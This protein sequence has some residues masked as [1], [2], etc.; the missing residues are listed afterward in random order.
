MNMNEVYPDILLVYRDKAI[1]EDTRSSEQLPLK[2]V[3]KALRS[4]TR[5]HTNETRAKEDKENVP[6]SAGE[7]KDKP[8]PKKGVLGIHKLNEIKTVQEEEQEQTANIKQS[9]TLQ[10][11][12]PR[13]KISNLF[14]K[15]SNERKKS[16]PQ[17]SQS[18]TESAESTV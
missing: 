5:F 16:R 4:G 3:K 9:N 15:S 12:R 2:Y 10:V 6:V 7:G 1:P 13:R 17:Q 14:R 8:E 11:D 18:P